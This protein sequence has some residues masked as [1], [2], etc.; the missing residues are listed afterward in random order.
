MSKTIAIIGGGASGALVVLNLLKQATSPMQVLWFDNKQRF[1]KGLAYSTTD[2]AHL[3]NVRA[4]NMSLFADEPMHFFNWLQKNNEP[5]HKNSFVPRSIY[6]NYICDTLHNLIQGNKL[7]SI[8]FINEEVI[9][10]NGLSY[11]EIV[12]RQK[13]YKAEQLVLAFGNFLPRHPRSLQSEF[14]SSK[15]YFRNA[16]DEKLIPC[17]VLKNAVTIVGSGLTMIDVVVSLQRNNFRGKINVISPHGYIPQAHSEQASQS[18]KFDIDETKKYSLLEV[19]HLVN[20]QIKNAKKNNTSLHSLI[21]ALR[22]HV[23]ILWQQFTLK[24]KQ[25]FLRHLRHKWGVA[26]HRASLD[27]ME[28]ITQLIEAK[29][30]HIIKGRIA[31]I[32]TNNNGFE[33]NYKTSNNEVLKFETEIIINC[34]GPESD[35]EN[36]EMPLI[37]Q[38]LK[39]EIIAVDDLHYGIKANADG[40]ISERLFTLGSPL[41][42]ILWESTAIPEIRVQAK[43]I[44]TILLAK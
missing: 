38:L 31:S 25:Q 32:I 6:G 2:I 42:G 12:T 19:L 44:A 13:T 36:I 28:I 1:G 15:N 29:Q 4:I 10:I 26:R 43:N 37:Q 34:T 40:E 5:Y 21:D 33:V 35:F 23:Q 22:P 9:A 3:L 7:V 30:L 8:D 39:D 17:A 27:R 18:A 41:K 14:K 11:F 24:D 20:K 16:F